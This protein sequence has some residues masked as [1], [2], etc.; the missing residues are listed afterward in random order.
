MEI[1][2][3]FG[4]CMAWSGYHQVQKAPPIDKLVAQICRD[5]GTWC[6]R[7]VLVATVCFC[8]VIGQLLGFLKHPNK[9][10][11]R[12]PEQGAHDLVDDMGVFFEQCLKAFR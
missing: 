9:V 10:D 5:A 12:R 8:D 4:S 7:G 3:V 11:M 6:P 1:P 2:K